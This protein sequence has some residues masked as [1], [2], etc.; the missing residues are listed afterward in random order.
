MFGLNRTKKPPKVWRQGDVFLI[1]RA[2]ALP[3]YRAAVPP[4]LA[5]GE[6]TGHAH[7]LADPAAAQL[8]RS[9]LQ[10][11]LEVSA[12]SAR[13]VHEEHG[14]IDLPRGIYEVRIQREYIPGA[15]QRVRD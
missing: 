9:G 5:E 7:R 1:A 15:D 8:Y 2:E 11:Y 10:L 6:V 12:R 13:I 3:K 14:P 4:V